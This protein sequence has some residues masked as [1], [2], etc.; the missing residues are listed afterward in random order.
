MVQLPGLGFNYEVADIMRIGS[1]SFAELFSEFPACG[2]SPLIMYSN[3]AGRYGGG[4][5]KQVHMYDCEI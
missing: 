5:F 3:K 1:M 2:S 4:M